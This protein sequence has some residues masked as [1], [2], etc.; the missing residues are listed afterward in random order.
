MPRTKPSKPSHDL[1]ALLSRTEVVETEVG[2]MRFYISDSQRCD[3]SLD[4]DTQGDSAL[5]LMLG[6]VQPGDTVYDVGCRSGL[7]SLAFAKAVGPKGMVM[8]FEHDIFQLFLAHLNLTDH[9]L[10]ACAHFLPIV[11]SDQFGLRR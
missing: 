6:G 1:Q 9:G 7:H 2:M 3:E 11:A 5:S 4:Q 8:C 10:D